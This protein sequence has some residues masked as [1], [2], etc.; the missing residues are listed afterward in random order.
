MQPDEASG[1]QQPEQQNNQQN[2]MMPSNAPPV[3]N[4]NVQQVDPLQQPTNVQGPK[5]A[6]KKKNKRTWIIVGV[7]VGIVLL[8]LAIAAVAAE[9]L[10][11][12][13]KSPV[14][15]DWACTRYLWTTNELRDTPSVMLKLKGDGTFVYGQYGDLEKNHYAGKYTAEFSNEKEKENLGSQY[16]YLTFNPITEY[17]MEGTKGDPSGVELDTME[18][19]IVDY[20]S[21]KEATLIS[22]NT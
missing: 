3:S 7:I 10:T 5:V 13:S 4:A 20:G 12:T 8:G 14:V 1:G 16:Y 11:S 22:E 19:G 15:G 9:L 2:N 21:Y 18:M 6:T 17:V